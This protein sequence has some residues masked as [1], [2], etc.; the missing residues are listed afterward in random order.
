MSKAIKTDIVCDICYQNVIKNTVC[1]FDMAKKQTFVVA[2]SQN[3]HLRNFAHRTNLQ[4]I[5]LYKNPIPKSNSQSSNSTY[6]N[7]LNLYKTIC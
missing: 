5:K 2:L 1:R 3:G 7:F 4:N 6:K